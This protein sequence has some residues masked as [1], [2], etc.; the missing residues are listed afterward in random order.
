MKNIIIVSAS[1]SM[2]ALVVLGFKFENDWNKIA[3]VDLG[4][5][6]QASQIE[7]ARWEMY[8]DNVKEAKERAQRAEAAKNE[9][10]AALAAKRD[11]EAK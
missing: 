11:A 4:C 3:L 8:L 2:L 10:K 1:L 6:I 7:M 9:K 5:K